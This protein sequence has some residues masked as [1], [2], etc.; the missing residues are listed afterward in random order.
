MFFVAISVSNCL[1]CFL[2][3]AGAFAVKTILLLWDQVPS[4]L[5]YQNCLLVSQVPTVARAQGWKRTCNTRINLRQGCQIFCAVLAIPFERASGHILQV[6]KSTRYS[7]LRLSDPRFVS[8]RLKSVWSI[9]IANLI[10]LHR[11]SSNQVMVSVNDQS[12]CLCW[13]K[14]AV[15]VVTCTLILSKATSKYL[16]LSLKNN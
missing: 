8:V 11:V 14:P 12:T 4:K 5:G 15:N 6:W 9:S 2:L 10:R 3:L 13:N 16:F 7:S 1:L